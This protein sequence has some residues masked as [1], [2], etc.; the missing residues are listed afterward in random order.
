MK[1][2]DWQCAMTHLGNR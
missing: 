1:T 2:S